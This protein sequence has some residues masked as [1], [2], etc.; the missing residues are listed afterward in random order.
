MLI[1]TEHE[2]YH[3]HNGILTYISM[4]N[5]TSESLKERIQHFSFYKLSTK[6]MFYNLRARSLVHR[7]LVRTAKY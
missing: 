2:I 3:A 6:K 7:L 1:S 5:T 4:M